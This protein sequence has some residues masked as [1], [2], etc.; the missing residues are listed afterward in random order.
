MNEFSD[1]MKRYINIIGV[2]S[3]VLY[4]MDNNE[5]YV[6]PPTY[7]KMREVLNETCPIPDKMKETIE[8]WEE[9][10]DCKL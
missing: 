4:E 6:E 9:L 1:L 3:D 2:L 5:G 10:N 7:L 8:V